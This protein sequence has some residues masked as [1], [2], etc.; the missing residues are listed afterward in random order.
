MKSTIGDAFSACSSFSPGPK[1]P[2]ILIVAGEASGDDHA[3]RLVA[4][5]RE[6]APQAEFSGI[7]GEALATQGVRILW[8]AADL[9][10]V[11]LLEVV[12]HLPSIW[13]ALAAIGRALKT[14]R[15]DLV[16]LVDFPDFNFWVA[17]LAKYYGVPV[18]Y[19]ISPQVWAWPPWST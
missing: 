11:G 19:Y 3:A 13:R 15:P 5:I 2:Q 7:G 8:P 14:R 9:A 16:I 1:P 10:V 4:A 6:F 18:L 17:R 12:H